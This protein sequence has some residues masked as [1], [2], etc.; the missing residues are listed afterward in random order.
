MVAIEAFWNFQVLPAFQKLVPPFVLG[1]F[2]LSVFYTTVSTSVLDSSSYAI[3]S[4]MEL[5]SMSL[6]CFPVVAVAR[7][8]DSVSFSV[9]SIS[10]FVG[11]V[12]LAKYD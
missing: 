6:S 9:R 12:V 1:F 11:Y 10:I 8:S 3:P 7:R 4:V 2:E 5:S